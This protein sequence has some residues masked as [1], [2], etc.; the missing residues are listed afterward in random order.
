MGGIRSLLRELRGLSASD[1]IRS[2][3]DMMSEC[4][5]I[6]D[7]IRSGVRLD[8]I[9]VRRFD[10]AMRAGIARAIGDIERA[11]SESLEKQGWLPLELTAQLILIYTDPATRELLTP[12]LTEL[13]EGVL[14]LARAGQLVVD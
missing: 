10:P 3:E 6:A 7:A 2:F 4:C 11:M 12:T 13:V 1:E 9:E 8:S 5:K 14:G